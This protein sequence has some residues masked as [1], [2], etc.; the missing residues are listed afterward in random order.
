MAED[1]ATRCKWCSY[2]FDACRSLWADQ[3]KCCPDCEHKES[4]NSHDEAAAARWAEAKEAD[5]G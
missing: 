3:R 1:L 2:R 4:G 5:R